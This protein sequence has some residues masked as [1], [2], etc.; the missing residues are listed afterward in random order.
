MRLALT[1]AAL[2]LVL[3]VSSAHGASVT[4]YLTGTFA[5]GATLG[6]TITF[7]NTTGAV[8]ARNVTVSAPDAGTFT[9]PAGDSSGGAYYNFGISV[10]SAAYPELSVSVPTTTGLVGYTG[11]PLCNNVNPSLCG[12][13][14][15]GLR[16]SASNLIVL[17]SGSASTTPSG[18][19]TTSVPALSPWALGVLALLIAASGVLLQRRTRRA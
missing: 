17:N 10:T 16:T 12:G 1:A 7:D 9:Y 3:C 6:G 14:T 18:Q 19:Q 11:G 4:L 15:S 8:T 13:V 2:A 5:D